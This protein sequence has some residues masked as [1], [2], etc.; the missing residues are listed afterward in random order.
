MRFV[1][2]FWLVTR[3]LVLAVLLASGQTAALAHWDGAWYG[4][5]AMHGYEFAPDGRQHNVAFFPL[6]P[7]LAWPLV[8]AGMPWPVA[9]AI[10]ANA[11]FLGA[12]ALLFA[13]SRRLYDERTAQWCVALAS[14]LPASLFCTV[15]YPQSVFLLAS[16][17]ALFLY[18]TQRAIGSGLS[19]AAASAASVLG[20]PLIAALLVEAIVRRRVLILAAALIGSLGIGAYVAFCAVTFGD[21]LAFVHAQH[22]WRHGF[23]FDRNAWLSIFASLG[24]IDGFRQNVQMVLVPAGLIAV[25]IEARHLGRLATLYGLLA[26]AVLL[27]SGTPFSVDR[28][29]YAIAPVL[30]AI[31]ALL[32]RA[33][34]LGYLILA[35][36]AVLLVID[37]GRFAHFAWVA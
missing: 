10:V 32:R 9:G 5:I 13:W 27:F 1:V 37:A 20:I 11:A 12:L 4:S 36:S 28:N 7:A 22:A 24:T 17:G 3:A 30:V 16:A 29:A 19:A 33:P 21:P 25:L 6:F 14:L 34:P 8:H 15:D 26:L 18:A 35:V 23:G 31:A 2:L